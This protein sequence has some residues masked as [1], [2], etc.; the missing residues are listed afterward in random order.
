MD[1]VFRMSRIGAIPRPADFTS[2]LPMAPPGMGQSARRSID[3]TPTLPMA[4]PGLGA[5]PS[6]QARNERDGRGW[7]EQ[8]REHAEFPPASHL[9]IYVGAKI[10]LAASASRSEIINFQ[11]APGMIGVIRFFGNSITNASD[12]EFVQFSV[13]L[14]GTPIAGWS[15]FV[16]VRSPS[17]SSPVPV[18]I[19]LF[20]ASVISVVATNTSAAAIVGVAAALRGWMWATGTPRQ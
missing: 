7:L 6:V 17:I 15:N 14:N 8:I 11:L 19:P 18:V 10:T 1:R 12:V 5:F 20:P 9:E 16:G 3:V 2:R 13:L 4:A